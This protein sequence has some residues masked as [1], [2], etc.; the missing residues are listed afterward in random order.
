MMDRTN[1]IFDFRDTDYFFTFLLRM[2]NNR[3]IYTRKYVKVQEILA[4]MGGLIKGI[5]LIVQI[6]FIPKDELLFFPY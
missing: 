3:D 5:M 2:S 4:S 6:L 1:E